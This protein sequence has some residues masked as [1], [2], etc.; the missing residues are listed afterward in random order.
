MNI[1][2]GR[3]NFTECSEGQHCE[4]NLNVPI[5]KEML[6]Q[7]KAIGYNA[8][9]QENRTYLMNAVKRVDEAMQDK[10]I[11]NYHLHLLAGIQIEAL[12]LV[13]EI[14]LL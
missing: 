5:T 10:Q 13:K 12:K 1:D 3:T 6:D 9:I 7:A 4:P 8:V 11:D 2:D 14:G